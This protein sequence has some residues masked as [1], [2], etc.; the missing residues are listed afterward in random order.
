MGL[1]V[2]ERIHDGPNAVVTAAI[3]SVPNTVLIQVK[4]APKHEHGRIVIPPARWLVQAANRVKLS[5]RVVDRRVLRSAIVAGRIYWLGQV[6]KVQV[7]PWPV[8]WPIVAAA[9]LLRLV[10]ID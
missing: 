10:L 1:V 5:E 9:R 7:S 6:V 8:L 2:L 4:V 3:V